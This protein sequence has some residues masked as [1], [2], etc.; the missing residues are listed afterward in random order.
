MRPLFSGILV[1]IQREK[2]R[3]DDTHTHTPAD[4]DK[5]CTGCGQ[6]IRCECCEAFSGIALKKRAA[7]TKTKS[8]DEANAVL[9]HT[10]RTTTVPGCQ[11]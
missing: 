7:K 6:S 4:R 3:I 11:Q 1:Q 8:T 5:E 2:N 10:M 9:L